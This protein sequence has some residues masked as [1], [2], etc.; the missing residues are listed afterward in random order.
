MSDFNIHCTEEKEALNTIGIEDANVYT[1]LHTSDFRHVVP[2]N[3]VLPGPDNNAHIG[4]LPDY[5]EPRDVI[6]PDPTHT[7]LKNVGLHVP[8]PPYALGLSTIG[9]TY[10]IA[11]Q[12]ALS[13][14]P[15][16]NNAVQK[17][18][19][20]WIGSSSDFQDTTVLPSNHPVQN[21][22]NQVD[23]QV[24]A[25]ASH[26]T[27]TLQNHPPWPCDTSHAP[28][29]LL[30]SPSS[31]A[32]QPVILFMGYP[33]PAE[34]AAGLV[35]YQ[36]SPFALWPDH[37]APNYGYIQSHKPDHYQSPYGAAAFP[38]STMLA[39]SMPPSTHHQTS[40]ATREDQFATS[41]EEPLDALPKGMVLPF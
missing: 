28:C 20:P 34:S 2:N 5:G 6:L 26:A 8:N 40:K 31:I 29:S 35:Q 30:G 39:A 36:G 25:T 13:H 15:T 4:Y 19:Q 22:A 18:P 37:Q 32:S 38:D 17:H 12:G 33:P 41:A 9:K 1:W 11:S 23:H 14:L 16:A 7:G 10:R 3:F 27:L 21:Y 24:S